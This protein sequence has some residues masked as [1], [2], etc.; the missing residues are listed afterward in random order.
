MN[1][2]G[3]DGESLLKNIFSHKQENNGTQANRECHQGFEKTA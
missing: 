3:D 1:I 2:L